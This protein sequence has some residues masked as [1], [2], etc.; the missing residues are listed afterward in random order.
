MFGNI[1][2]KCKF[3]QDNFSALEC[4]QCILLGI[5]GMARTV[6]L[7]KYIASHNEFQGIATFDM[8]IWRGLKKLYSDFTV[9]MKISEGEDVCNSLLLTLRE[10]D[11]III[12]QQDEI[13]MGIAYS[14]IEN[15]YYFIG[16]LSSLDIDN[17]ESKR[18]AHFL[19]IPSELIEEYLCCLHDISSPSDKRI[20]EIEN[21]DMV[22]TEL[23]NIGDDIKFVQ[24]EYDYN[25]IEQ[26]VN[27][28]MQY[29][30]WE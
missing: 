23:D 20:K 6:K 1:D 15:W 4:E 25:D 3:I 30:F 11:Y 14:L 18:I 2:S 7:V 26:R 29:K 24:K 21:Y 16:M 17:I 28:Y 12:D 5:M 8:Y 9:N 22:I 10:E 19:E 27:K 13:L